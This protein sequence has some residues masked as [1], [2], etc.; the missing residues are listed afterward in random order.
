MSL[1]KKRNRKNFT[2]EQKVQAVL[3]LWTEQSTQ[4]E[5]CSSLGVSSVT[6]KKWQELAMEAMLKALES[7][8]SKQQTKSLS[9]RLENLLKGQIRK[10]LAS[11]SE[12]TPLETQHNT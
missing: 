8:N 1:K 7:Q 10:K 11:C 9:P 5:L 3:S 6:L 12:E 2:S 4:T